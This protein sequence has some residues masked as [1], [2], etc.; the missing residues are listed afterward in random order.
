MT[1][2]IGVG[3]QTMRE[4]VPAEELPERVARLMQTS[5]GDW[6]HPSIAALRIG[7]T[8]AHRDGR[9][10]GQV[11]SV[12]APVYWHAIVSWVP[13]HGDQPAAR[14]DERGRRCQVFTLSALMVVDDPNPEG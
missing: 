9:V 2:Y 7:S 3:K 14:T 6:M 13:E 10:I 4:T 5:E 11:D 1:V 8:V 12:S